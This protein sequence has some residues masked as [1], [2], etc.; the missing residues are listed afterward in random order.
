MRKLLVM[1]AVM[2]FAVTA[3]GATYTMNFSNSLGGPSMGTE[4]TLYPSDVAY[5]QIW[6][7]ADL[8]DEGQG[9]GSGFFGLVVDQDPGG[10]F[11]WDSFHTDLPQY[12][13]ETTF[14]GP[15]GTLNGAQHTWIA[16]PY[17]VG[18][19]EGA[20]ALLFTLDIH[21]AGPDLGSGSLISFQAAPP[22]LVQ[23]TDLTTQL[24]VTADTV[25]T[26]HQMPEPA[27]LG[28]LALGGLALIRRR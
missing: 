15:G 7:T 13:Y 21:C 16:Y 6:V 28:L 19:P 4:I 14:A 18:V 27:S 22:P 10:G 3:Y 11:T 8:N 9:A 24:T 1:L 12:Y 17:G 26:V 23:A 5:I 2:G 25:L 20:T